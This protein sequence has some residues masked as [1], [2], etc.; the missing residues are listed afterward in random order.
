MSQMLELKAADGFKLKAYRADPVGKPFGA[1]VVLQEIFG[2]NEHIRDLVERWAAVGYTAIA[3]ALYDRFEPGFETGY[4][5]PDI[6]LGRAHKTSANNQLDL[7]LADVEAARAAVAPAGRVGVVGYCWGG[8][9]T[10]MAACRLPVQAAV[11]Y[12]GGGITD[13]LGEAPKCPTML[14]F[15][16]NDASIPL[17]DVDKIKAAHPG[18]GI[19]VYKAGHGFHCDHRGAYDPRAAAVAGMRTTQ[20]FE[21]V[22]RRGEKA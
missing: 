5:P 12:Y 21:T 7:V 11:G 18:V 8:F 15:G 3:P 9:I 6:E 22:L 1:V 20:F 16:D 10:Y 4:T 19:H 14:H 2:V 13:F 17:S